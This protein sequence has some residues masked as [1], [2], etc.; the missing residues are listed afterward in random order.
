MSD[1]II[2]CISH[3]RPENVPEVFKTSGTDDI[4]FVVNNQEDKIN[5]QR[6]GA[7]KVII[8]GSLV[9]NRNA[10]LDYCFAFNK[11]CVQIDDDLINISVNDFTGKRTKQYVKLI[12]VLD[13]LIPEFIQSKHLFA[14]AP[15]TEN[16]FF[17]TK[18]S[19]ENILITAPFTLT[20]PNQIRF[21]NNL[22]LKEDYDYTLQH[23]KSGGCIRYHK[24][25]FNFKRYG[26]TG[27]AVSYRTDIL[28][29]QAVDYL[30][31]KWEGALKLNP[32]RQ[33]ELLINKNS[34]QIL[35][36]KQQQLF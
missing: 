8:G 27:G 36:S 18:Q 23:I 35:N 34:Y 12:D 6:N 10:A 29:K 32:K 14:G 19:Q 4:V 7:K 24:Y 22:K 5:Y 20:K 31:T 11:I 21:D 30:L 26:N 1:Y 17:A 15:P 33:N 28:E 3:K 16:P 9:G 2:T 25:L 13:K